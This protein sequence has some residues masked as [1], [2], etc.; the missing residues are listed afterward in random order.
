MNELTRLLGIEGPVLFYIGYFKN[1]R[2][3]PKDCLDLEQVERRFFAISILAFYEFIIIKWIFLKR[4]RCGQ[5]N[6]FMVNMG[7]IG[8]F[9]VDF[10]A[11]GTGFFGEMGETGCRPD[12][13]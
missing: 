1:N 10:D 9:R 6:G 13:A 4:L 3:G 11:P 5:S 12:H 8:G 2:K 7:K